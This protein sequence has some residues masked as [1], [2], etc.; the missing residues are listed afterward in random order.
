MVINLTNDS[1]K[2]FDTT[3]NIG[4]DDQEKNLC[5]DGT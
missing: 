5:D 4:N 1:N 2:D 3:S